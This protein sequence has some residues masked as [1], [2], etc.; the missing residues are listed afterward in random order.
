MAQRLKNNG[1]GLLLTLA[2]LLMVTG[3]FAQQW[4]LDKMPAD[5]ETD[6]ALHALPPNLR[7]DA[8]VY[9]L[10][11]AKGYYVGKQ[12][13]S[14]FICFVTRTNWEWAEYRQDLYTP[15]GY[16]PEG[17]RTIFPLYRDAAAMRA[18][19]MYIAEQVRDTIAG[20]IVRGF[21]APPAK[22]GLSYMLAPVMRVYTGKPG[23]KSVMTMSMPHFMFYAPYIT[24]ADVGFDSNSPSG[25]WLINSGNTV[26]G[27]GKGP[28]GYFIMPADKATTAKIMEDG[29]DLVKRL[30]AYSHYFNVEM[31]MTKN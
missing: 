9:L 7:A 27:D 19:G 23:D 15:M 12:G 26:L 31:D 5:L 11:P 3:G 20:R 14:G 13:T 2:L 24:V 22:A 28:E 30:Q 18:T 25:P 6:L 4:Q 29:K 1:R 10:D 21:Y 17:A 8:T 16:D